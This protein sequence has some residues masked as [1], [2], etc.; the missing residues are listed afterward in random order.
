M[1]PLS[2]ME[3][4]TTFNYGQKKS[5]AYPQCLQPTDHLWTRPA[6]G[7]NYDEGGALSPVDKIPE[8]SIQCGSEIPQ[9]GEQGY[10]N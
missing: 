7:S 4:T 2:V 10:T 1:P 6:R 9:S 8:M 5:D 3:T